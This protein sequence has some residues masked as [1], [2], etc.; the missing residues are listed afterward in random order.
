MLVVEKLDNVLSVCTYSPE[1]RPYPGLHQKRNGQQVK[2]GDFPALLHSHKTPPGGGH[3][4]CQSVQQVHLRRTWL[5]L[6]GQ[7]QGHGAPEEFD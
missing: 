3:D 7:Q 4:Q 1:S 6:T 5:A 2:G